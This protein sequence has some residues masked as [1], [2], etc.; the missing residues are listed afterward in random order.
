MTLSLDS[1]TVAVAGDGAERRLVR[2]QEYERVGA[3]LDW[4][5]DHHEAQ[6]ALAEIAAAAGLSPYHFQRLFTHWVGISPKRF[7]QY[8]TLERA[9]ASLEAS[10]SVLDAAFDAGLS[11]PGRLHDLFVT[12]AAVTP[13]E[14]K[15]RGA[16]LTIRY[17]F[18]DSPFGECLMLLSDRG[19]C[20]LAF[21]V[22]GQREAAFDYLRSGWENARMVADPAATAPEVARVFAGP[23]TTGAPLRVL[24]RGTRF[25]LKVWEALLQVPP[26]ALVSYEQIAHHIG[27]PRAVR[28]VGR[29]NAVNAVCYLIPCHRVIRKSGVI[30][31]YRWGRG[32]KLALIGWEAA[33]AERTAA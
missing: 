1:T 21:V 33:Q 6:P 9:K 19:I 14:Y 29:A 25:Q 12:Y 13:G 18:H 2:S 28:A 5:A 24:L 11:G 27:H 31:G 22:D 10:A 8:L 32:R 16:G 3:A 30:G 23:D 20:G 4:L 17:G 15:S 7:L 26:G